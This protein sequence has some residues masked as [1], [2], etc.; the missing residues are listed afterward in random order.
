MIRRPP[1]S[2]LFPYTTLF[3]SSSAGGWN[4]SS[5]RSARRR[6][7]SRVGD[8][9]ARWAQGRVD[10]LIARA[11][12]EAVAELRSALLAAAAGG[13]RTPAPR[14]AAAEPATRPGRAAQPHGEVLCWAYCVTSASAAPPV[15]LEGLL[16]LGS[17]LER[18]EHKQL[19]AIVSRV[20]AEEYGEAALHDSLNDLAWLE[21]VARAHEAVLERIGERA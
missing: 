3:R 12:A 21:R 5:G 14:G 9:L 4:G 8:D 13:R 15:E 7:N 20:P 6:R 19:A 2:T 18:V 16:P 1:R 10:A 11:E 17:D